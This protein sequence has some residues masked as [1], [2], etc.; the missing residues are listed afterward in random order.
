MSL[1]GVVAPILNGVHLEIISSILEYS[2]TIQAKSLMCVSQRESHIHIVRLP[3][4][5][6]SRTNADV[7]IIPRWHK[8]P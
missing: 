4:L 6:P 5:K 1:Y 8:P 7:S 3:P 2:L